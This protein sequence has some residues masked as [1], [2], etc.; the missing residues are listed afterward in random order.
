MSM[1]SDCLSNI[2][3]LQKYETISY[4]GLNKLQFQEILSFIVIIKDYVTMNFCVGLLPYMHY[5]VCRVQWKSNVRPH[6][7]NL[8]VIYHIW[9]V[10]ILYATKQCIFC[11]TLVNT[12]HYSYITNFYHITLSAD[13]FLWNFSEA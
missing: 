2:R 11:V 6:I 12:R 13:I 10:Y 7:N 3:D 8:T 9:F 1:T 5:S 4:T